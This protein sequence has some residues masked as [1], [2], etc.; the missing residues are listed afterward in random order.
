M[1]SDL[2]PVTISGDGDY[3]IEKGDLYEVWVED[4]EDGGFVIWGTDEQWCPSD[5]EPQ[6]REVLL[7]YAACCLCAAGVIKPAR[8][9]R[10]S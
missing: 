1:L 6:D 7:E 5:A 10:E 9:L 2:P 4:H 8:D 3:G